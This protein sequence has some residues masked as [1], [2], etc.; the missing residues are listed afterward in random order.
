LRLY[1]AM[2]DEIE[3]ANPSTGQQIGMIP[4]PGLSGSEYVGTLAG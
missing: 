3:I 1:L 2:S 4:T